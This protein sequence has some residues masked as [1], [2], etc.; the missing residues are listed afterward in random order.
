MD[1][2]R[3][4]R[5]LRRVTIQD[6]AERSGVSVATIDRILNRRAEVREGTS[7]H[8]LAVAEEIGFY[9]AALLRRRLEERG[10]KRTLG[11]GLIKRQSTF[12]PALAGAFERSARDVLGMS[13]NAIVAH[14]DELDPALIAHQLNH[15]AERCDA[16]GF[17]SIDDPL[18][19]ETVGRIRARGIPV[20]SLI[21]DVRCEKS[22]FIGFDVESMSGITAWIIKRSSSRGGKVGLLLAS[23][24]YDNQRALSEA[25]LRR[26]GQPG[27]RFSTLQPIVTLG[28]RAQAYEST[29]SLLGRNQDLVGLYIVGGGINGVIE[30]LKDAGPEVY[31]KIVAV[32]H[33]L[34]P[35]TSR[36]LDAGIVDAVFTTPID[37]YAETVVSQMLRS[38][39]LKR[40]YVPV[41]MYVPFGLCLGD[42]E[43]P[44]ALLPAPGVD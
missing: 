3:P 29:R 30:A 32:G 17:I 13:C 19:V 24:R 18:V 12:Y 26:F 23:D 43:A 6:L 35:N 38:I 34:T 9:N 25:L 21:S 22:G 28:G 8:V 41:R 4:K 44:L 14:L 10:T 5:P 31:S 36:A 33:E 42:P 2:A 16:I 11:F 27:S 15:L 1:D 39:A 20:F 40:R 7:A 37:H